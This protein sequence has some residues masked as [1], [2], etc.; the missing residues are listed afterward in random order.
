MG[1]KTTDSGV[2]EGPFGEGALLYRV[3][4]GAS[5]ASKAVAIDAGIDNCSIFWPKTVHALFF[6]SQACII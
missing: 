2:Q 6:S 4:N 1:K 5:L 3:L